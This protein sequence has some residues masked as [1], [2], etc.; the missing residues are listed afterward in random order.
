MPAAALPVFACDAFSFPLPEGHR[1]PLAK[2]RRLREKLI[3]DGVVAGRDVHLPSPVQREQLELAH[4]ADYVQR[5][6][7]GQLSAA[8]CRRL[9]F[10][11][12]AAL[13]ERALRSAGGTLAA[14]RAALERGVGITL[15]G[16]THHAGVRHG[17]GFCLFN[18]S[19]IA[20]R[21]L[22]REGCVRRVVV[23][24]GDV[25]QGN[26]TAEIADGDDTLF[27][28]SLHGARNFPLR[29]HPSDLDIA[30]P[31]GT[32]DEAFLHAWRH[33]V[34]EALDRSRAE[35]AIYLAGAD[36]YRGDRLGR[37]AVSPEGLL[38]R[39]RFALA[40]CHQRGIPVVVTMAG[41]YARNIDETVAIQ[42]RTVQE[43]LRYGR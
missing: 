35:M 8:E 9:G 26:G 33:G 3:A 25:H 5:M 11:W 22:Q 36:P 21:V 23:L 32:E 27:T 37:L 13:V 16:G 28:F 39:D 4:D 14:A 38:Q 43:A 15:A 41:G 29:K 1:F 24:D 10:P 42:A 17:E 18:D 40:A 7:H 2:F 34:I 19:I 31:D 12:S 20:A 30:L 6:L